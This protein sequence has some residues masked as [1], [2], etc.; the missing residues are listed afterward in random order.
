MKH[1]VK[2]SELTFL[3]KALSAFGLIKPEGTK[4]DPP[5][6]VPIDS[7]AAYGKYLANYVANC[8]GCHTNRDLKTGKLIGKP[9][10]GGFHMPADPLSEDGKSYITPNLTPDPETG[11]IKDWDEQAFIK[12]L[13]GGRVHKSSPMPWGAFGRINELELKAIYRYLKSL[14]PVK[15][16]VKKTVYERG[17][18]MPE[19]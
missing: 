5:K 7:T 19:G 13:H 15:N 4:G 12:R 6:F 17:E 11:W 18:K 3:G 1:V 8:V 10:S 9:F 14:P 16:A 2:R